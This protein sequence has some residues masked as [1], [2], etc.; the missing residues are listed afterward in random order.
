MAAKRVKGSLDTHSLAHFSDSGPVPYLSETNL[1][2][3]SSIS[4]QNLRSGYQDS[5]T[6]L[7]PPP[8]NREPRKV[9]STNDLDKVSPFSSK[10]AAAASSKAGNPQALP[11]IFRMSSLLDDLPEPSNDL[12]GSKPTVETTMQSALTLN[13]LPPDSR[14][15]EV[16]S[17]DRMALFW[18]M[19]DSER[20]SISSVPSL[21]YTDAT[22]AR[23]R[24]L[25][26]T[27]SSI[28]PE[29]RFS[30][31][32]TLSLQDR[33]RKKWKPS[34]GLPLSREIQ[35]PPGVHFSQDIKQIGSGIGF[36]YTMPVATLSKASIC[37]T[38]PRSCHG[39]FHG[40][41][42]GLG[43]RLPF[44]SSKTK[45]KGRRAPPSLTASRNQDDNDGSPTFMQDF[46]GSSWSLVSPAM[47]PPSHDV[48]SPRL[49]TTSISP[50]SDA[51]PLTPEGVD[52]E[53]SENGGLEDKVAHEAK[54][55]D[56]GTTL[57]LISPLGIPALQ[58]KPENGLILV[59]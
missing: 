20:R 34:N 6:S 36:T 54:D 59:A 15:V 40:R 24:K 18:E 29:Q 51:G 5:N 55:G 23:P 33:L 31:L 38:T 27:R 26:K 57:R 53:L 30:T 25:R 17:R 22:A 44:G 7:G 50:I 1:N 42:S 52:Y 46:G 47:L 43:L 3:N 32:S 2:K 49:T 19:L 16:N 45:V 11:T 48:E 9:S 58:V 28:Y 14:A 41:V 4:M 8:S 12:S 13:D 21:D 35:K 39:M 37:T 10:K 56:P